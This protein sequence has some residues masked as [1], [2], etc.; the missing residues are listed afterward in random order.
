MT[1]AGG[2]HSVVELSVDVFQLDNQTFVECQPV[3]M[4]YCIHY[5]PWGV[6]YRRHCAQLQHTLERCRKVLFCL[7]VFMGTCTI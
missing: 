7:S 6:S 4:N 1:K 5:T 3:C 2:V